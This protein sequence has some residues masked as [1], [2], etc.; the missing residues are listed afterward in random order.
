MVKMDLLPLIVFSI[1]FAGLLT[2]MGDRAKTISDFVVGVN[3]ALMSFI[4]LI[5]RF[6]P[7]G[8][9]LFGDVQVWVSG[10]GGQSD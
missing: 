6:A 3:D 1:A 9:L 5:M 10:H 8:N 2:T 4:L 7:A